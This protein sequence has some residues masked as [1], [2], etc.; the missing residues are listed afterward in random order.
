MAITSKL[1]LE[2]LQQQPV[3][4]FCPSSL[5]GRHLC[6]FGIC[7]GR[8]SDLTKQVALAMC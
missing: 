7:L 6:A 3:F 8:E 5:V 1:N 2:S 4:F